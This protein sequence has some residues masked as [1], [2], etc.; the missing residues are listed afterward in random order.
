[1]PGRHGLACHL[2]GADGKTLYCVTGAANET[3]FPNRSHTRR[4]ETTTIDVPGQCAPRRGPKITS[5]GVNHPH[6]WRG[7]C[8]VVP[9]VAGENFLTDSYRSGP[10]VTHAVWTSVS[11]MRATAQRSS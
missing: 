7:F 11:L 6:I 4:I 3:A 5:I 1:V 10:S 2:G 8:A 9:A